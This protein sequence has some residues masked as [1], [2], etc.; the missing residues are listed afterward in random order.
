M[1][2]SFAASANTDAQTV[3]RQCS[4]VNGVIECN[5]RLEQ[6]QAQS[7][8]QQ[9]QSLVSQ[10][11]QQHGPLLGYGSPGYRDSQSRFTAITVDEKG[12]ESRREVRLKYLENTPDGNKRLLIFDKPLDLK[13]HAMLTLSHPEGDDEHWLYNPDNQ[14]VKRI[15]SNNTSTPFSG[16]EFNFEDLSSQDLAKYEYRFE[17]KATF[18]GALCSVVNRFPKDNRSGYQRLETWI[19]TQTYLIRKIDYYDRDGEL[20][21]TLTASNYELFDDKYWR[22]KEVN[23]RNHQSGKSTQLLWSDYQ[24]DTGLAD[25]DFS[26]AS[27]RNVN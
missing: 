21:K 19:D 15:L 3:Q 2:Q 4:V 20:Y 12:N 8:E 6:Q 17:R 24:F 7:V 14:Q 10:T 9:G 13:R 23:I 26:L 18:D 27:L 22:A 16:S 5:S 1:L 25:K 11:E